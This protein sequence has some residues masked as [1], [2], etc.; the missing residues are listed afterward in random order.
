MAAKE[1]ARLAQRPAHVVESTAQQAG[2]AAL[3]GAFDPAASASE[4]ANRLDAELAAIAT[5]LVAEADRDDADG[6]YERGDAVGFVGGELVAW[7][8][9]ASTLGSVLDRI[10]A[11]AEIVTVLE[12]E[13]AP[14]RAAEAGIALVNGAEL[15]IQRGGQPTYWWLIAA[16]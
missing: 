3:V 5:G 8:E 2:L 15:E 4:N 9:P 6:R 13:D 11:D 16:Q 10:G 1:A 7:G 14:L 12:G